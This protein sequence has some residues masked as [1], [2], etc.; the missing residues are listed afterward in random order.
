[1][2]GSPPVPALQQVI[3]HMLLRAVVNQAGISLHELA[4]KTCGHL[5]HLQGE[6]KSTQ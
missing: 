6:G 3:Q 4:G 5:I 1:M 2:S